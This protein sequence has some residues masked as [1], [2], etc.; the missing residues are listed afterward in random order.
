M[1]MDSSSVQQDCTPGGE[2]TH[3][4][5]AVIHR[6]ASLLPHARN[7][8]KVAKFTML[9]SILGILILILDIIAIISVLGSN[10]SVLAKL[11]WVV[12]ILALPVLGM[13]LYFLLGP[14]AKSSSLQ[15]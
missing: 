13:I 6:I 15:S 1:R 10:A 4:N 3:V 7:G 8:R 14:G 2:D 5:R 11:L 9:F 12:I